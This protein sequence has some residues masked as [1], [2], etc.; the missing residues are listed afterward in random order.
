M[1]RFLTIAAAMAAT[2]LMTMAV[3]ASGAEV[4]LGASAAQQP[5]ISVSPTTVENGDTVTIS[6]NLIPALGE[7][8]GVQLTSTADLFPPDG[9]GPQASLG[10]NGD[11]E[12]TYTV[13]GDTPAGTYQIGMRCGGGNV[14]ESASLQVTSPTPSSIVVSP[15]SVENGDTVTI[16]G[17]VIPDLGVGGVPGE[18][19]EQVHLTSSAAFFPPDGFGPQVPL[20]ADGDFETTY[21]VPGDTPAGTYQIGMRCGGG[22]VGASAS[23]QVTSPAAPAVPVPAEPDFTG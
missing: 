3:S 8:A 9:F 19:S 7:C 11:F 1:R 10:A 4:A 22:N 21:T 20:D 6:G 12:T 2:A 18:C 14:G 17:H 16:S 23:L 15:T 5:S 13:P